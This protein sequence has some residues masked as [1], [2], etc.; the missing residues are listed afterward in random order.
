MEY[1]KKWLL[2]FGL[3]IVVTSFSGCETHISPEQSNSANLGKL[4][5]IGDFPAE[6]YYDVPFA[7]QFGVSGGDGVYRYRYIQNP[8]NGDEDE[9]G[10]EFNH[11]SMNI[12]NTDGAKASFWLRGIPQ[13]PDGASFDSS[14]TKNLKF[15]LEVTDGNSIE[16]KEYTFRLE[17]NTISIH[18]PNVLSNE[19]LANTSAAESLFT[20]SVVNQNDTICKT[21]RDRTYGKTTVGGVTVYPLTIQ[22]LLKRPVSSRVELFYEF[23]SDYLP[24]LA[25]RDTRNI[26]YAR[27]GV[28]Y[29]DEKDRSVVFEYGEA[30]CLIYL[31]VLDDSLIEG[32]EK[33]RLL[34]TRREGGLVNF[35][36]ARTEI[37]IID[38]EPFPDFSTQALTRNE[39]DSVQGIVS[40]RTPYNLPLS[41]NLTV[42]AE[43]STADTDDYSIT[44]ENGVLTIP[45]GETSASYSVSLL[46]NQDDLSAKKDDVIFLKTDLDEID[47]IDREPLQISINEWPLNGN[48]DMEVVASSRDHEEAISMQ[49]DSDGVVSV[50]LSDTSTANERVVVKSFLRDASPFSN[51]P[52]GSI[53]VSKPGSDV[54]PAAMVSNSAGDDH[55]LIVIA[56]VDDLFANVHRGGKDFII[57]AYQRTERGMYSNQ[58]IKQYGTEGDDTV[59]GAFIDAS[60]NLYVYGKTT[61]TEFDGEPGAEINNGGDDGFVYRM[62]LGGNVGWSRFVGSPELDSII[63]LDAGRRDVVALA[64]KQIGTDTDAFVRNLVV[65][66]G[67]NHEEAEDGELSTEQEENAKSVRF[68]ENGNSY[69]VLAD[70]ERTEPG[71]TGSRDISFNVFSSSAGGLP[72]TVLLSTALDDYGSD[73][74]L[75]SED[76]RPFIGGYT[77]GQ[78][79]GNQK[80]G[81]GSLDAFI[82]VMSTGESPIFET[83]G[84]L[85][86]GTAGN[87]KVIDVLE[88]NERKVMVLWS[89][90]G[91]DDNNATRYRISAFSPEGEKLSLNP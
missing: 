57:A 71:S 19:G 82:S 9:E 2:L 24:N 60:D 84:T 53:V 62:S 51:T 11:V 32:T 34:F 3:L 56:M 83:S 27:P 36:S 41:I 70:G 4:K 75:L 68:S 8:E 18:D 1:M 88:V 48:L 20:G 91:S 81:P 67:E 29:L 26:G 28:D 33:L 15:Q 66:T 59:N 72:S 54:V 50:L 25:E 69:F 64:S 45:A 46:N 86:F 30:T 52:S 73:M 58:F 14:L 74:E 80:F 39:G 77:E 49:V 13:L 17:K 90:D 35:E 63:S 7:A 61:G 42:D 5:I 47:E 10:F 87:D 78:F 38:N 44:P 37:A 43:N 85:Q 16:T 79:E 89:E 21:V 12:E 55:L 22:V 23:E 31:N 40:L 65:R 6:I 76:G